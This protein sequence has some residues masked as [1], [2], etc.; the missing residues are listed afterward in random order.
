MSRDQFSAYAPSKTLWSKPVVGP[1][2]PSKT[3]ARFKG[4]SYRILARS[5]QGSWKASVHSFN[6]LVRIPDCSC[7]DVFENPI[8]TFCQPWHG[9]IN[10]F[11]PA[12]CVGQSCPCSCI[13]TD[14]TAVQKTSSRCGE[15]CCAAPSRFAYIA[16][17][18][19]QRLVSAG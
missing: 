12:Y 15:C 16:D 3:G 7:P 9:R 19:E 2:K 10:R 5:L 18:N 14:E 17:P 6:F 11:W 1:A 4:R 13:I 8:A